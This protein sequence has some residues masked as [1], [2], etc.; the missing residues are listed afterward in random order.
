VHG[1]CRRLSI[2][3]VVH[4]PNHKELRGFCKGYKFIHEPKSYISRNK[5]I[6]NSTD[7]IIT[8]P[9]SLS[10][11]FKSDTWATIRYAKKYLKPLVIIMLDGTVVEKN[12][13]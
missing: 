13:S 2:P 9:D 6:V 11:S 7:I 8:M 10:E 3:I 4:P 1:I 5:Y 12:I